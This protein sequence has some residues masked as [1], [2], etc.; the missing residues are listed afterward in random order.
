MFDTQQFDLVLTD[1]FMPGMKGDQLAQEIK[2]R[3]QSR[4]VVLL[5]AAP[6]RTPTPQIDCIVLKPFSQASLR[7]AITGLFLPAVS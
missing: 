3:D 6:P 2:D 5:T 7:L 4:P 1:Y